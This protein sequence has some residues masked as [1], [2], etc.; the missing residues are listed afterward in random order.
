MGEGLVVLGASVPMPPM[1][2]ELMPE[3]LLPDSFGADELPLLVEPP[4]EDP[5]DTPELAPACP[6]LSDGMDELPVL[7]LDVLPFE[8]LPLLLPALPVPGPPPVMP[9][10]A[11]ISIAQAT[12]IN[13]LVIDYSR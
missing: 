2:P 4:V 6:P 9:V 3:E 10:H 13:H 5:P 8:L 7:P 11:S 12:D 1:P